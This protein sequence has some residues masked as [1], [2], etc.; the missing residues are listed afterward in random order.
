MTSYEKLKTKYDTLFECYNDIQS[1]LV[2]FDVVLHD[3]YISDA[4]KVRIII[5]TLEAFE[6]VK[7]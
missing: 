1:L 4:D 3:D 2:K 7:K 5:K 6:N